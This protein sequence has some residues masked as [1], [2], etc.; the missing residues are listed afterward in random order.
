VLRPDFVVCDE[1]V[2]ALDLSIQAQIIELLT[3]LR[4][5]LKLTYLFISHDIAVVAHLADRIAIM[6][7]GRFVEIGPARA[8]VAN[9]LHPYTQAL[10]AAVPQAHAPRPGRR[11]AVRGEPPSPLDPPRGCRFHPRCPHA[12][13]ICRAEEPRLASSDDGRAAACHFAGKLPPASSL[14]ESAPCNP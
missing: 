2:A 3:R 12:A 4:R 1:P 7:L 10:I 6:Y 14:R 5:E 9:P 13:D 8:V 11:I